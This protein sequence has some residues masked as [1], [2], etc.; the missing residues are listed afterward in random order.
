M[1]PIGKIVMELSLSEYHFCGVSLHHFGERAIFHQTLTI[2]SQNA[3]GTF[4]W[5]PNL[6]LAISTNQ[7]NSMTCTSQPRTDLFTGPFLS[8]RCQTQYLPKAQSQ[9]ANS[10]PLCILISKGPQLSNCLHTCGF[11]P[12]CSPCQGSCSPW[13]SKKR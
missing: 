6:P 7:Q 5:E 3:G 10:K 8:S 12:S 4:F 11:C 13:S 1:K 9:R 2:N